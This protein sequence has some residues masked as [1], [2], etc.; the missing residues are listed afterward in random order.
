VSSKPLPFVSLSSLLIVI[1][2]EIGEIKG[3]KKQH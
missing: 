2:E 1:F 3:K